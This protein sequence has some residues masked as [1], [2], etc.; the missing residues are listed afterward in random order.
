VGLEN[1]GNTCYFNSAIHCLSHTQPLLDYILSR[2]Y[3]KEINSKNKNGTSGE[4]TKA[5]AKLLLEIWKDTRCVGIIE[6]SNFQS[7]MKGESK[8]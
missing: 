2:L 4:V 8:S 6:E 7:P 3:E 5:F 1:L